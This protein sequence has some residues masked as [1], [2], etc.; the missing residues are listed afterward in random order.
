MNKNN[1]K[2][3][4][5]FSLLIQETINENQRTFDRLAMHELVDKIKKS[6]D[7]PSFLNFTKYS[8]L[9]YFSES[10]YLFA[11]DLYCKKT[12]FES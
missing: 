4:Y 5:K 11:V 12:Y 6:F 3:A 2:L 1:T 10:V 7:I 8:I 9:S